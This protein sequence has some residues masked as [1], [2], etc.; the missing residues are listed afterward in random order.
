[1]FRTDLL[2]IIRSHTT[3]YTQQWV[4]VIQV[5]LTASEV[6]M[7]LQFLPDLTSSQSA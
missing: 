7:E 4:V 3:V 5:M 2:S 6:R 1:M